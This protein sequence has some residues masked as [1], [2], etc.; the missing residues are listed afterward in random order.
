MNKIL[1]IIIIL[2]IIPFLGCEENVALEYQDDPALYFAYEQY[3]QKD[4]ISQTFFILNSSI[5][6]DTVYV[7][8]NT[9]GKLSDKDRPVKLVQ[10]NI[11]EPGAAIPGV[12]YIPFEDA[13]VAKRFVIPAGKSYGNVPVIVLR[14][15]SL[16]LGVYRLELA[17]EQ[18]EYFRPGIN[19]LCNF[20]VKTTAQTVKPSNWDT[21]WRY[22]FGRSWGSVKM[23]FIIDATGYTEW[24]LLPSDI[25]FVSFLSSQVKLKFEEYNLANPDNPLREA[26]GTLVSF[27]S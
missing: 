16:E 24:E 18:N 2:G 9:M 11:G 13:E 8:I 17:I 7:K 6:R 12:H 20:V 26:D 21:T 25:S 1:Y 5:D 4:S 15:P 10:T 3:G 27:T 19:T 22:Y 14:D 23:R